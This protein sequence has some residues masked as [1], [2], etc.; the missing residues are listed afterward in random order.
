[1][2]APTTTPAVMPDAAL[3]ATIDRYINQSGNPDVLRYGG[4]FLKHWDSNLRQIKRFM[5]LGRMHGGRVLDVGC[6]FG[7]HAACMSLLGAREVVAN[8]IRPLMTDVVDARVAAMRAER[9]PVHVTTLLGDVCA[10]DLPPASFDSIFCNQTMEHVHDELAMFVVM[11]R[12]LRRGGIALITN[13]NNALNDETVRENSAMWERRDRSAEFVDGL[14]R[15]RPIENRDAKPYASMRREIIVAADPA[16]AGAELDRLVAGTAGMIRPDILRSLDHF[17]S[18][19]RVPS[20]PRHSWC[21]NPETGE[22]CERL[23]DPYDLAAKMES[24]GFRARVRHAFGR[25]P[26]TLL[27]GVRLA[28]LNRALFQRK[29]VFVIAATR[30]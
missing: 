12:L 21:R 17:R 14:R 8:D 28:P 11:A 23:L 9:L 7:W 18:S 10:L 16:L 27:N 13:D 26:A 25:F 4:G 22:F 15:E 5:R 19:G 24:H 20:P 3:R 1:M 2:A 29:P 6:G 30:V